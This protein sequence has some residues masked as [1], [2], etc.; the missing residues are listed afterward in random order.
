[1]AAFLLHNLA[2]WGPLRTHKCPRKPSTII[3]PRIH[4][5]SD[6]RPKWAYWL[7]HK[8]K[9]Y[10]SIYNMARDKSKSRLSRVRVESQVVQISDLIQ[11]RDESLQL[12]RTTLTFRIVRFKDDSHPTGGCN[13]WCKHLLWE[14]NNHQRYG[15]SPKNILATRQII[16]NTRAS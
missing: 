1:M 15:I 13:I 12:K 8:C 9:L 11:T 7:G 2:N 4:T 6:M 3:F 14:E 16:N 10:M 5:I